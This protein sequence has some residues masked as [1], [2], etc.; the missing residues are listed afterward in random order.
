MLLRSKH[1]N[2]G[3]ESTMNNGGIESINMSIEIGICVLAV[4]I[5]GTGGF[6]HSK[7]ISVS[8][9]DKQ[10]TW[11][12]DV[13]NSF[14]LMFHFG[15]QILM[16]SVTIFVKDLHLYTGSWLCYISKAV[17]FYGFGHATGHSLFIAVLKYLIVVRYEKIKD[18]GQDKAKKICFWINIIYPAYMLGIFNIVRPDFFFNF[19]GN[20]QA[21][22]CLGKSDM[23]SSQDNNKTATQLHN[24]CDISPPLQQVSIAYSIYIGR[25]AICWMHIAITYCNFMNIPEAVLY[26]IVF[27][28][29]RR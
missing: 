7:V 4:L 6:L 24:L 14:M 10:M 19:D 12:I 28:F 2:M 22:R 27:N 20:S 29:M 23:I 25:K 13:F 21:N 5:Y 11:M 9:Q 8:K 18:F 16:H 15:H 1:L 17:N 3:N 26:C